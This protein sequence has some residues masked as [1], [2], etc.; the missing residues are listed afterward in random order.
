MTTTE[1]I[2]ICFTSIALVVSFFIVYCIFFRKKLFI[3]GCLATD[4]S[5]FNEHIMIFNYGFSLTNNSIRE[6]L[7]REAMVGYMDAPDHFLSPMIIR[8]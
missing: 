7:V 5:P 8:N 4:N 2:T 3:V 1:I 6:S